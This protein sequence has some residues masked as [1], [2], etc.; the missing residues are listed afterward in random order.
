MWGMKIRNF[1]G[2]L[3]FLDFVQ[4]KNFFFEFQEVYSST[5]SMF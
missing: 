1:S 4:S 5:K 2:I 3:I